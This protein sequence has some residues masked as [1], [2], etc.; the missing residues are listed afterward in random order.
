MLPTAGALLAGPLLKP[1]P[2]KSLFSKWQDFGVWVFKIF[3]Q[4]LL[5]IYPPEAKR[6][7]NKLIKEPQKQ[8]KQKKKKK[9]KSK[10]KLRLKANPGFKLY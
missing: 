9:N 2:P 3:L 5:L 6:K 7:P 8:T 10:P 4:A 1:K